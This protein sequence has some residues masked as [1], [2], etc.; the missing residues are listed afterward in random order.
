[1]MKMIKLDE[2]ND[3]LIKSLANQTTELSA[4]LS[5]ELSNSEIIGNHIELDPDSEEQIS[6]LSRL[7]NDELQKLDK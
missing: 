5:I 7:L 3:E 1:M 2:T 6:R 4:E